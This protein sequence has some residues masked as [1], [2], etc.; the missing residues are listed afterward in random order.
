[1][2]KKKIVL[3]STLAI[4]LAPAALNTLPTTQIV[5]ADTQLIGTIRRG[6]AVAVDGNGHFINGAAFGNFT[7]WK[8]GQ[9][10]TIGGNP[11][12]E[13]ATNEYVDASSM[14]ITQNGKL[15]NPINNQISYINRVETVGSKAATIV[16]N[17][18]TATGVTLPAGSSWKVDQTRFF[19]TYPYYRVATN[20]WV[21]ALDFNVASSVNNDSHTVVTTPTAHQPITLRTNATLYNGNGV[22]LGTSLPKGSSWKV[23]QE[24]TINGHQYYQVATNEW[25]L[26]TEDKNTSVFSK[27]TATVT[28]AKPVQLYDT[29]SNSMT[30]TLPAGS[31][32]KVNA[33]V[34][35]SAGYFF[36]KVS[37]NEWI[38]LGSSIFT[39]NVLQEELAN[40]SAYEPYFAINLFK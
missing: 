24:K 13:V 23:A 38:P 33:T 22:S 39:D 25:V 18:G 31:A 12:Y 16:N 26:A 19:N 7:S 3:A 14:D 20:E 40:S 15:L 36:A 4:L 10:I 9:R 11:Y 17:N 2:N 21:K 29:S 1:M 32:W 35:N 6:G 8:L 5:H 27:G 30:R 37:N 28:L 34:E